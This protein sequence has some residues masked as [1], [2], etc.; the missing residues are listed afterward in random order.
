MGH[1]LVACGCSGFG[2]RLCGAA[3]CLRARLSRSTGLCGPT[4][5]SPAGR[6]PGPAGSHPAPGQYR[7][8][9]TDSRLAD[10]GGSPGSCAGA[11]TAASTGS[12]APARGRR[13]SI[14]PSATSGRGASGS[15]EPLLCLDPRVLVLEWRLDMD[16]WPMGRP[17]QAHRR[18]GRW[19]LGAARPRLC[20]D[21]RRL[22]LALVFPAISTL[23]YRARAA[24][25]AR[26]VW[27]ACSL[28]PLWSVT[29]S[30]RAAASCTH[31]K[32][33]ASKNAG[34]PSEYVTGL[35]ARGT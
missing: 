28:L 2:R 10:S 24:V 35:S 3:G 4:A 11:G 26:S 1:E 30:S 6:L 23:T 5:L 13:S 21:R 27:S 15:A 17:A 32:R 7:S 12:C 22:A 18:L 14:S 29:A 33:F 9:S 16:R 8:G 19:P 34:L 31:S 20:L 25:G